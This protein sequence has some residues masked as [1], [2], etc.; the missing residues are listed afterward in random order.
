MCRL[1]S[2]GSFILQG[3]RLAGTGTMTAFAG[4]GGSVW[5]SASQ[6]GAVLPLSGHVAIDCLEMLSQLEADAN[7]TSW[8]EARDVREYPALHRQ[9][10]SPNT[11]THT[12]THKQELSNLKCQQC[13]LKKLV[14]RKV[15][16]FL[17]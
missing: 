10:T 5:S 4:G 13:P 16:G 2:G 3:M 8:E 6:A 15:H 11:H 9:K 14:E 17:E 7:G 1:G 12:Y